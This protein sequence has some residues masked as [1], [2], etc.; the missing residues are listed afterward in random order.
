MIWGHQ[1]FWAG[2]PKFLTQ[3][4]KFGSPSKFG[5]ARL[6]DLKDYV[7]KKEKNTTKTEQPASQHT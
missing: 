4:Y 3:F 1:N 2:A 7:P 6:S 5:D